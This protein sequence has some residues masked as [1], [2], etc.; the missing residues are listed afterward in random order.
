MGMNAH[1]LKIAIIITAPREM[2]LTAGREEL[3]AQT[4][5]VPPEE[6]LPFLNV[7]R[8]AG[9]ELHVSGPLIGDPD[10]VGATLEMA[11]YFPDE[12][13]AEAARPI[14]PAEVTVS[15]NTLARNKAGEGQRWRYRLESA[16]MYRAVMFFEGAFLPPFKPADI[17]VRI[18]HL[19]HY[20]YDGY[21]LSGLSHDYRPPSY[22]EVE[23]RL[24]Q[25]ESEGILDD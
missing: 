1:A 15:V 4:L 25:L 14:D 8:A 24:P 23:W 2:R 17:R 3:Q 19:I 22:T 16:K 6:D 20:N 10:D 5:E 7:G 18:D 21:V 13:G 11:W 9:D 12:E